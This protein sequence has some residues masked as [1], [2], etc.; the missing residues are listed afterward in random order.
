MA[1]ATATL[2]LLRT[3]AALGPRL[4][5]PSG[6]ASPNT[7]YALVC[8]SLRS[9]ELAAHIARFDEDGTL[10]IVAHSL[11][12]DMLSAIEGLVGKPLLGFPIVSPFYD[13][14]R[15]AGEAVEVEDI[16]S[17]IEPIVPYL[18]AEQRAE[19]TRQAGA[20]CALIA[21]LFS[22]GSAGGMLTVW[23]PRD[24]L[25]RHDIPALAALAAQ[26]GI[27]LENGRLLRQ[28]EEEHARWRATVDSMEELVITCDPAGRITYLN[29]A[30]QR[31]FDALGLLLPGDYFLDASGLAHADGSPYTRHELPLE[32]A[33]RSGESVSDMVV[34][35]RGVEGAADRH[36]LWSASPVC[37]PGGAVLGAVATGRDVTGQ[38]LLEEMNRAALDVL[39][40]VAAIVTEPAEAVTLLE[41]LAEALNGLAAVEQT[42]A[43]L[44]HRERLEPLA[45]FGVSP[46]VARAW[47]AAVHAWTPDPSVVGPLLDWFRAG[48]LLTQDFTQEKAIISTVAIESAHIRAAITAPVLA[49][50]ELVGLLTI[51]RSRPPAPDVPTLFAPW[52]QALLAGVA[53]L[54]G[55]AL[56]R[57]RLTEQLVATEAAR[58]AAVEATHQ[59]DEFLG[60]A[61]HELRTPL[62][63]IRMNVQLAGRRLGEAGDER[64]RD[65]LRRTERQISRM[66]RLVEDLVDAARIAAD[67]LELHPEDFDLRAVVTEAVEEQRQVAT[68]RRIRLEM[69]ER[70]VTV[71]GD[72]ARIGQVVTNYLTNALKYSPAEAPVE[73]RL[74]SDGCVARLSVR[75][76]GP[77]LPLEEQTHIWE[78]FHQVQGVRV[79][80]GSGVGL[81][82][83]LYISRTII[84][85]QDGRVG[86][87]SAL[88][89]GAT[90]WFELLVTDNA[91]KRSRG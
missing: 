16:A 87:A 34:I 45:I 55:E 72:P 27:A 42:H 91:M 48:H 89:E 35:L 77:G 75:D 29:A 68:A 37:L 13:A 26:V 22:G 9:C 5:E 61:S 83:G 41:R 54:A 39:L 69:P 85:R 44:I 10:R 81:G 2:R 3:I 21:P 38:R 60:V 76:R 47:D 84:E 67:K 49:G 52:D 88:G 78:R 28:A 59:R 43:M 66:T 36:T 4:H 6:A 31:A 17:I 86:V 79:Q 11:S 24:R 53:R 46:G 80:T 70:A 32:V 64:T 58:Q 63:S 18:T 30:A 1:S 25:G 14:V 40:R 20:E 23:G 12:P 19:L 90:F 8:D 15:K 65:L 62:T 57:R 51:S 74:M 82:L 50:G 73:V 7:L 71:R 56:E 33:R